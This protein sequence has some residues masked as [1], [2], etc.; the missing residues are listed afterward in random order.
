MIGGERKKER[1]L[2]L[3]KFLENE[4]NERNEKVF[5]FVFSFVYILYSIQFEHFVLVV[6]ALLSP[7]RIYSHIVVVYCKERIMEGESKNSNSSGSS[8][9]IGGGG[10]PPLPNFVPLP[11]TGVVP[12]G[13][14][15]G[16]LNMSHAQNQL[17][18]DIPDWM[19]QPPVIPRDPMSF[20]ESCVMKGLV[21]VP[22]GWGLGLA[23]GVLIA[24]WESMSPPILMPGVPEPPSRPW[25]EEFRAAGI[26]MRRKSTSWSK[27]FA[28]VTGVYSGTE[29]LLERQRAKHDIVNH[30]AAGCA[31]GAVLAAKHGPH[32]AC[33]GCLGFA[34]FSLVIETVMAKDH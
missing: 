31:T 21:S 32:A 25:R 7:F 17:Y 16:N 2:L 15:Q 28:L 13:S 1:K 18:R 30:G 9:G 4:R 3:K 33:M 26:T 14:P 8:N 20:M 12:P 34:A 27:N 29:C 23:F 24:S 10:P 6:F 19:P 11:G 22:V 5:V